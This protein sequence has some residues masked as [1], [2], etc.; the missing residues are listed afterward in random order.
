MFLFVSLSLKI[1][2]FLSA[3]KHTVGAPVVFGE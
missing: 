1:K 3:I 2:I